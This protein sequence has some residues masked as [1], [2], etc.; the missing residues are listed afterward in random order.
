MLR[1]WI[2]YFAYPGPDKLVL[3]GD[4]TEITDMTIEIIGV[5]FMDTIVQKTPLK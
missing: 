5:T 4:I 1:V 3:F 2:W